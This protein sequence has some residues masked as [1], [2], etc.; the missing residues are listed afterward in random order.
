[1]QTIYILF[2]PLFHIFI[3][4]LLL[5]IIRIPEYNC[6]SNRFLID[7]LFEHR[8]GIYQKLGNFFIVVPVTPIK[9]I[10]YS[11]II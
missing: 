8:H 3:N 10:Y 11:F 4:Q 6:W 5:L 7:I 2:P 1:M 9:N